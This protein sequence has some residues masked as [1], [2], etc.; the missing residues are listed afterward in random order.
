MRCVVEGGGSGGGA[1]NFNGDSLRSHY[2]WATHVTQPRTLIL[3]VATTNTARQ[4][5]IIFGR[6]MSG[7]M[8]VTESGGG[9]GVP[10]APVSDPFW[11]AI[12]A[13]HAAL[14]PLE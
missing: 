12:S 14:V 7:R 1:V 4:S 11:A 10:L 9:E 3:K 8:E 2:P 13:R 5:A 6:G